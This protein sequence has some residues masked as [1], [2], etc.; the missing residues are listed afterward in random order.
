MTTSHTSGFELDRPGSVIAAVPAV[1]GFVPEMSLVLV[2]VDRGDL[3]CVLRIDLSDDM[4]DQIAHLA[5]VAAAARP[6]GAIAVIVDEHGAGCHPCNDD[7]RDVAAQLGEELDAWGID[8][9]GAHVV[10]R[11]AAGGRWH[12]AD[13]CGRGG[14]IED[15]SAS[16]LA[17]AAV[18]DGRRLYTRRADL[19]AV[20]AADP[21]RSAALADELA[22]CGTSDMSDADACA[23]I[24]EARAAAAHVADG[25]TLADEVAARL[26]RA[27]RDI[28]VRDTLFALA[29]GEDADRAEALWVS[30][31]RVLPGPWR[32]EAL[33]LVA[34]SAYA[35]G[36]GPLAGVSL[37][38]AL[39][40]DPVHRMASMLDQALQ[41]GMRPERIRE[42]AVTGYRLA[43]QLGVRLPP[44]RTGRRRAG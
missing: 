35:R 1:L 43:E 26:G 30:L 13:G 17:L 2:T 36:D 16:P 14:V 27:L 23:A 5:G 9:L 29:V 39:R 44:R 34:F 28:R 6:D 25:G 11:V 41:S 18:L 20:I 4:T 22:A 3:G 7:Y 37:D 42:L 24:S 21:V 8:L 38:A 15:P 10:D 31:A 40:I 33:V 19:Q 12:C 32:V